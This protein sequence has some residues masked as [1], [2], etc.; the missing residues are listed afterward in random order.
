MLLFSSFNHTLLIFYLNAYK[1][2]RTQSQLET[3]IFVLRFSVSLLRKF[4]RE[5]SCEGNL[6]CDKERQEKE[7]AKGGNKTKKS[8]EGEK[9][10][11]DLVIE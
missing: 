1:R 3:R 11:S 8:R 2:K 4:A 5:F 10:E 6:A 7:R 9:K